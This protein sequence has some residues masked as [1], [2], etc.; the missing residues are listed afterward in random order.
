[1]DIGWKQ[2]L[3]S[4]EEGSSLVAVLIIITIIFFLIGSVL[5]A[6]IIQGRFIQRDIDEV[7]LRYSAEAGIHHFLADSTLPILTGSDLKIQLA[8]STEA[9]ISAKPF[10]G[11][12]S[13]ASTV[14]SEDRSKSIRTLVGSQA[15][16][17]FNNAVVLGDLRSALNLTG[18]TTIRGDIEVGPLSIKKK[19]FKGEVFEGTVEGNIKKSKSD[20]LPKF[21]KSLFDREI[22]YCDSLLKNPPKEAVQIEAGTVDLSKGNVFQRGSTFFVEGNLEL[23]ADS[24]TSLP[25]EII[26]IVTGDLTLNGPISYNPFS[27]FIVGKN[28]NISGKIEGKHGL[29]YARQELEVEAGEPFSGQFIAGR[30]ALIS[31]SSYLRY[32]SVVYLKGEVEKNIRKGRVELSGQSVVEGT[33]I[34]PAPDKTINQDESRLVV[35]N[36]STVRGAIFNTGQTELHGEVMGSV[37]TLQ[38]Y[39][40][41]SPT[42]YIN[43]LKDVTVNVDKRPENFAIPLGFSGNRKFQ[44]LVWN[45]N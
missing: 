33:L 2:I 29:F 6:I 32:P 38:F 21:D 26:F 13:L 36:S 4:R 18:N 34:I 42:S 10:G 3:F 7:Q 20:I 23:N 30:K 44:I 16:P 40:Y 17:R 8:D 9:L 37:L 5:M 27:R 35:G 1:M 15:I 25:G 45:E 43:W 24:T 39:F 19:S 41:K 14:E 12:L 11:F 28:L 22:S 31:G